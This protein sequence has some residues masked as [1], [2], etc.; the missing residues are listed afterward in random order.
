MSKLKSNFIYSSFLTT[1]GYIFPLLTFPYVT[2]TLGTANY[3]LVNFID[4]IITY[5]ILIA[6]MGIGATGIKAIAANRTRDFKEVYSSLLTL[7]VISSTIVITI[8]LTCSLF[9]HELHENIELIGIGIVKII[10]S[11][12]LIEWFFKGLEDFRYITLRTLFVRIIYV[13]SVFIFVR[14]R[15]DIII[16]YALSVGIV[17]VN[18]IINMCYA[19]KIVSFSF[20]AINLRGYYKSFYRMGLYM[21]LISFYNT[22][23]V[24][25]LGFMTNSTQ[26][27]YYTTATKIYGIL[28]SLFTAFT[29]VMLPRMS[30]L[31]AA[32][33]LEEFKYKIN[34]SIHF[35]LSFCPPIICYSIL[36]A[37]YIV[38][39][40][41]G[42]GYEGAIL[43]M[44]IVMA[45]LFL[46]GFN[47]I[48]IMQILMP[49]NKDKVIIRNT[50]IASIVGVVLNLIIVPHLFSIGSALVLIS[51]EIVQF[52]MGWYACRQ[53]VSLKILC[54]ITKLLPYLLIQCTAI[55][56]INLCDINRIIILLVTGFITLITN[57]FL[58]NKNF[59]SLL[60]SLLKK[61]T[62]T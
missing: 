47:Q 27:A 23:N 42:S 48:F 58:I 1:A 46:V 7:H 4:G 12:F 37:K 6:A 26:V 16:Y 24:V 15:N 14:S 20:K 13:I 8:L 62:S 41:V 19:N 17:V 11:A 39:L 10:F 38:P 34:K 5:A 22:L 54:H 36:E 45:L 18:A 52:T 25:F 49:M 32:D 43:P 59:P 30:A 3:G 2:R 60:S 29:G 61:Y 9:I 55:Q 28:L 50:F 40:I 35:L 33:N 57:L 44:Q 31:I 21:I 56:L 51:A 53:I